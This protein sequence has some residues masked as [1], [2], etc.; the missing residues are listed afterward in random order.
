MI[1]S[2]S[3][4]YTADYIATALWEKE[5]A[6]VSSITLIPQ[7]IDGEISNIAYID[8]Q[9]LC[10][11][12]AAYQFITGLKSGPFTFFSKE[13]DSEDWDDSDFWVFQKNT[14]NSGNL[15]VGPYTTT[16][17]PEFF[18]HKESFPESTVSFGANMGE[19]I[20]AILD[21]PEYM[22]DSEDWEEF[23]STRPIRGL[24]GV[25]YSIDGAMERLTIINE[26][27]DEEPPFSLRLQLEEELEHFENEVR[28]AIET[29]KLLIE[30]RNNFK[31]YSRREIS[32]DMDQITKLEL[33][34]KYEFN[35]NQSQLQLQ[36][37]G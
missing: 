23:Y 10:E 36:M 7:M 11:T 21:D 5:I 33:D 31:R 27:L 37:S 4:K 32:L 25:Y 14:H 17:T 13:D 20:S 19:V 29:R 28:N 15:S 9:S 26:M 8:I 18:A 34:R 6:K 12:E 2:I 1:A 24:D 35:E 22:Y 3:T 30:Q 16:F